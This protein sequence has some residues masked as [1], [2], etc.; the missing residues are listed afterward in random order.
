MLYR[1]IP[2]ISELELKVRVSEHYM[3]ALRSNE[4]ADSLLF[5]ELEGLGPR[6]ILFGD[7]RSIAQQARGLKSKRARKQFAYTHLAIGASLLEL[8]TDEEVGS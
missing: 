6:A 8:L 1:H 2:E 4:D 3:R 5:N 7:D